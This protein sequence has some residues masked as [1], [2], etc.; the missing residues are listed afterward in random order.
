MAGPA[1]DRDPARA[2][3]A[4][5]ELH[6][7][8]QVVVVAADVGRVVE[9]ARDPA[10]QVAQRPQVARRGV[11]ALIVER[12]DLH[13]LVEG[14]VGLVVAPVGRDDLDLV[15]VGQV[16]RE[17]D[18]RADR[19]AHPPGAHE[20]DVDLVLRVPRRVRRGPRVAH[21]RAAQDP[22][23]RPLDGDQQP[24][25]RT[26]KTGHGGGDGTTLP[27]LPC[28]RS[29][30]SSRS[31]TR[32][33][34]ID[35]CIDSLLGQTLPRG[36]AR[37]DLR[38]RRVHRRDARAPGRAGR[39]RTATCRSGTSRTP[40]WPG[41][42]RNIGLDMASGDYVYFIDNDDW[43]ERDALERLHATAVQDRADIVIGKV[44][45]HGKGVPLGIFEANRH[46]IAL[47]R[48]P[49]A[50]ACSRRTS[51]SGAACSTSTACASR[52]AGAGSRT[53]RSCSPPTSR[54]SGSRCWPTGPSTTG[55]AARTRTTPP[56]SASTP[57]ATTTTCARCSTSSSRARSP[58]SCAT[59]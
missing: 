43:I 7:G 6:V 58:A 9:R 26:G 37:A 15:A 21:Q 34:H 41:K 17:V 48:R 30:S 49:A 57:P 54:R 16:A 35:D 40:G 12:G 25:E 23:H 28:P 51:S 42:P 19:P 53:I 27:V 55:C 24:D 20:Q 33:P 52:R 14:E 44:V 59:R 8:P 5:H 2:A 38:R 22:P 18:R 11:R 50:R 36:R 1:G 3:Q 29:A 31:T 32:A 46:A 4:P 45:G 39:A 56:T 47:R 10:Q 13:A